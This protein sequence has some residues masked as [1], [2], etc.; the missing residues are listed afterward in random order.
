MSHNRTRFKA[1]WDFLLITMTL[2]II[3]LLIGVAIATGV[4]WVI[5]L[6]LGLIV[7]FAAFG[8]YGYSIQDGELQI[9]RLG[10]SKN[11]PYSSIRRVD[12][13][14]IAMMG[15]LRLFGIG[16]VF[17]YIGNFKNSILG[18]YKAYVTHRK[19]TVLIVTDNDQKILIS[20]DA[21]K[22]FINSLKSHIRK[23]S[24][25]KDEIDKIFREAGLND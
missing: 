24:R 1:P 7:V 2:G 14:P 12:N 16:G 21:P 13:K 15:S 20:P 6:N 22:E 4:P 11:I 5:L 23:E 19:K 25:G 10:W 18:H 8:V 17:G 3:S 9:V